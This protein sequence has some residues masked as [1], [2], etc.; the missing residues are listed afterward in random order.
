MAFP[1]RPEPQSE[2]MVPK[3]LV[4]RIEID[5]AKALMG[6]LPGTRG[7][8]DQGLDFGTVSLREQEF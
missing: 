3:I 5:R 7:R 1:D 4:R 6:H 2:S 8:R